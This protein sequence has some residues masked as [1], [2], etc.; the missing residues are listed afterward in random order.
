MVGSILGERWR[1]SLIEQASRLLSGALGGHALD[2]LRTNGWTAVAV[3][4]PIFLVTALVALAG[5]RAVGARARERR[6]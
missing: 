2:L 6:T 4:L 1:V 5:L 3:A